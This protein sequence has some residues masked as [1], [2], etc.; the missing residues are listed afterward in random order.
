MSENNETKFDPVT[1]QNVA[2]TPQP[3][4]PYVTGQNVAQAPQPENPYVAGQNTTQTPPP[5]NPYDPLAAP[6][7]SNK[8]NMK[9]LLGVIFGVIA[10]IVIAIICCAASGVFT[11]KNKKV[12]KAAKNTFVPNELMKD[13]N[14][15]TALIAGGNYTLAVEL[16]GETD[17]EDIGIKASY[18][19]NVEQK[20]HSVNGKV[21]YSGVSVDFHEYMDEDGLLISVP[22]QYPDVFG[23]YFN[24]EKDGYAADILGNKFFDAF[25][26]LC[27]TS[28][29]DMA[30]SA[31]MS[32][33][34]LQVL[35]ENYDALEFVNAPKATFQI[36]GKDV[37]C[38]GY[39]TTLTEENVDACLDEL[40]EVYDTYNKNTID[41]VKTMCK[42]LGLDDEDLKDFDCNAFDSLKDEIDGMPDLD[43]TFYIYKNR[44]AAVVVTGTDET[45]DME[46]DVEFRGGTTPTQNTFI[47]YGLNGDSGTLKILGK[48]ED[49]VEKTKIVEVYDGEKTTLASINYDYA[50]KEL[51]IETDDGDIMATIDNSDK[52]LI[53]D[54]EDLYSASTLKLT[55][56]RG[57]NIKKPEGDVFDIGTA[58]EDDFYDLVYDIQDLT[59]GLF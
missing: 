38:K 55:L 48:T 53:I 43:V 25:D 45:G 24:E 36:E 21:E 17:G 31:K 42:E 1:G 57:S 50:N 7:P 46:L 44:L 6:Q 51:E 27:L 35:K 5:Q 19:Q 3:E 2:Q 12:L 26:D 56:K 34:Y 52:G 8:K 32:A 13:L 4:N 49:S 29:N 10:V 54:M 20:M 30:A 59:R 28:M 33:D 15:G 47:T 22:K 16:A 18:Q 11:S 41:D 37:S 39:T 58:S 14:P 23:Y 40:S 9:I